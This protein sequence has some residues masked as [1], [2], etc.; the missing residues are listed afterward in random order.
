[1]HRE[2]VSS[3]PGI[4]QATGRDDVAQSKQGQGRTL[5]HNQS[6]DALETRRPYGAAANGASL[7]KDP[8]MSASIPTG[9]FTLGEIAD[10][11]T[12]N[13]RPLCGRLRSVNKWF[14]SQ[15]GSYM[16]AR[17]CGRI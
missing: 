8:A 2:H 1:M 14:P 17:P 11:P 10:H 5:F 9:F 13:T 6:G 7:R 4:I 3:S 16:V 15:S 12:A